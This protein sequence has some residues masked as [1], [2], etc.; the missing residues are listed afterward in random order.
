MNGSKKKTIPCMDEN[1]PFMAF[2]V[3]KKFNP[4]TLG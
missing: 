1:H 2:M 4:S 3:E